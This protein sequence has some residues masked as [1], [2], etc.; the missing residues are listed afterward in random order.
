[1]FVSLPAFTL[2][3]THHVRFLPRLT[4]HWYPAPRSTRLACSAAQSS[5]SQ[6]VHHRNWEEQTDL[7]LQYAFAWAILKFIN[8]IEGS[9]GHWRV[10]PRL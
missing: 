4:D 1:M 7:S 5:E 2:L 10:R 9:F 3:P 8:Q 6:M